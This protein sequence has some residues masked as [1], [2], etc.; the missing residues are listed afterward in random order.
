MTAESGPRHTRRK[1]E[2]SES[3]LSTISTFATS[4][5][6]LYK[7]DIIPVILA[8]VAL[9][10]CLISGL[11][12]YFVLKNQEIPRAQT[13]INQIRDYSVA[14]YT[15]VLNSVLISI[16]MSASLFNISKTEITL[17]DQFAPF[18]YSTGEF[19][20]FVWSVSY[21]HIVKKGGLAD[22]VSYWRSRGGEWAKFNVTGRDPVTNAVIPYV[23]D[24]D[25]IV[26]MQTVPLTTHPLI[27]G[28][29]L[30]SGPDKY[31]AYARVMKTNKTAATTKVILGNV[32]AGVVAS[33]LNVPIFN[34]TTGEITHMFNAAVIFGS[35]TNAA[36][37]GII[38]EDI[39]VTLNDLGVDA[40]NAT[41]PTFLYK[42]AT[43][44][45]VV[46]NSVDSRG[47]IRLADRVLELVLEP[48]DRYLERFSSQEK[49]V[50]IIVTMVVLLVMWVGCVVLFFGM[51]MKRS[52]DSKAKINR[53]KQV[54]IGNQE[55]L[56]AQVE[57]VNNRE[58]KAL[59]VIKA[60]PYPILI[61]NAI[62]TVI[63]VNQLFYSKLRYPENTNDVLKSTDILP[64]LSQDF[65]ADINNQ[66]K[67]VKTVVRFGNMDQM[68][69]IVTFVPVDIG[70]DK[71]ALKNEELASVLVVIKVVQ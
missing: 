56:R 70:I 41:N 28:Y 17:R 32:G 63:Q 71:D 6:K 44:Y 30:G 2:D 31:D 24:K 9:A 62:G 43:N 66:N 65:F 25:H 68:A 16:T 40:E 67:D 51:R 42:T 19:V 54:L 5:L 52:Y 22:F 46:P 11:V 36:L 12:G 8:L 35:L 69:G 53:Q 48:T 27:L 4:E 1:S 58:Q 10:V 26:I 34:Q 3:S 60:F 59:A 47:R 57:E 45:S 64:D 18:M 55:K 23:E 20:P 61:L 49:W 7:W 38:G 50:P 37:N 39:S 15:T 13:N 29:D 21:S 33:S 14:S